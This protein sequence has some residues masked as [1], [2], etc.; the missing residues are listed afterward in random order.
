MLIERFRSWPPAA[1]KE[2]AGRSHDG[3]RAAKGNRRRRPARRDQ[4]VQGNRR[5]VREDRSRAAA[6][7]LL[8]A[9]DAY[10]TMGDAESRKLY[11]QVI[12]EYPNQAEAVTLAKL[13]LG[14]DSHPPARSY[15]R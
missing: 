8:R 2:Y 3:G 9:A 7:A 5:Q 10:R 4:A 6:S 15:A 11:E 14:V 1:Q 13:R 12:K